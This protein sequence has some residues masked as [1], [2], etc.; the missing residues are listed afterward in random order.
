MSDLEIRKIDWTFDPESTPF[1]W[2]PGNPEYGMVANLIS[3]FAPAFERY[4]V[5]AVREAKSFIRGDATR[6]EAELFLR[7]DGLHARAHRNHL[8]ALVAQYPGLQELVDETNASH[9]RFRACAPMEYV[10]TKGGAD[11]TRWYESQRRAAA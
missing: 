1:Q 3:F 8:A 10:P 6:E 2:N 5:S 4:I 11:V 9:D 7:Q